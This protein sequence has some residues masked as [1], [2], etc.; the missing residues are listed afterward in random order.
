MRSCTAL[1]AALSASALAGGCGAQE[2]LLGSSGAYL[3]TAGDALALPGRAVDLHAQLRAG[4]LLR[5]QAGWDIRFYRDGELFK[6]AETDDDGEAVVSFTPPAAGDYVFTVAAAPGGLA[7][8]PPPPQMLLL[9]C[10]APDT[11]LAVV[12]LD[13]TVVASGFEAVLL[14]S[15]K[16]MSGSREVLRR[17]A[18]GHT[19]V[20]LTH[21]PDYFANKSKAWL[22]DN[23]YPAGPLLLSTLGGFLGGSGRFKAETLERLKQRFGR[24]EIGIGD[25]VSDARAYHD[26]GMKAILI[27]HLPAP[28]DAPAM[29]A[30]AGELDSLPKDV[31]VVTDWQQ[32]S[33]VLAGRAD[34]P[35]AAMARRLRDLAAEARHRAAP[36]RNE[37]R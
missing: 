11:P 4:D 20:Y 14:G 18:E 28:G 9:A 36:E 34:H 10:R 33:E 1:L 6:V 21:R 27:L 23:G 25:K 19:I 3:P 22:R 30:L 17:L 16:P 8:D 12:D 29:E 37:Q 24:V 2:Q 26:N 7:D 15:P 31:H 32:V 13:K 5:G 35:P